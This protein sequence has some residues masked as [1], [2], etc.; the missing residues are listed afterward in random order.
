M[1]AKPVPFKA[2]I[3]A[4][5]GQLPPSNPDPAHW[6]IQLIHKILDDWAVHPACESIWKKIAPRW[7][8]PPA[9]LI[10][11]VIRV[12][13]RLEEADR[14]VKDWPDLEGKIVIRTMRHLRE[15]AHRNIAR[16]NLAEHA[17]TFKESRDKL[18]GRK[19]ADGPRV[20][21]M[22]ALVA[23][24]KERMGKPFNE[25]VAHLTEIAFDLNT[26]TV[27]MVRSASKT[28]LFDPQNSV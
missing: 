11:S 4:Y 15:G 10:A 28:G 7:K 3:A 27:D 2:V 12:R 23:G 19:L 25:E 9:L 8:G 24:F 6:K 20:Y 16:E 5:R 18:F 22:A 21:F 14:R 26:V 17:A 1:A 13:I